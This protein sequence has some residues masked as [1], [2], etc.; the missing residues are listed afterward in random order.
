MD[1]V[2]L[3]AFNMVEFIKANVSLSFRSYISQ[4]SKGKL[5]VTR[6]FPVAISQQDSNH[7]RAVADWADRTDPGGGIRLSYIAGLWEG[8]NPGEKFVPLCRGIF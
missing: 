3:H 7:A 6:C 5:V 2:N 8:R 1:C 4:S